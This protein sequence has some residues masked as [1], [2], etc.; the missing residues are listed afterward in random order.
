MEEAISRIL[1]ELEEFRHF[2]HSTTLHSHPPLSQSALFDLQTLLDNSISTD[3]Q[4]PLDRL[5]EDLS[6]KSL[7]PSSLTRAIA[8]AMDESSTCVSVLASTVYLSLLLASNAPVFTL[9]N[10]MDFLSFLRCVRRFLKQRPQGQQDQDDSNKESSAPKRKRKAGFKGKGLRKRPRQSSSGRYDD[11]ELD[12]RVLYP[13]LERLEILMSVIHLDRFPDSLKSLIETV[14]DI[15]VLALEICTNLS[16]YSKFTDFC[17]RILS[18]M[19]RP[20]D[21]DLSN[22]AVEVIKSLSPLILNHKDQARAFALE[23]VTIQIGKV[24]KE[25]DGVKSALVNLPRYLV[26][27]APEKSEPRSLAVDSIMEVVKALELP[28][29]IGFVDYAVK[30]TQGKSNLRLLAVD[31]ISMLIMSLSDP[32][33]I[34][35]KIELKDSWVFGCLVAL[36]QRCSDASAPIRARALTNLA[37]LVVFLSENDKNKALMKEILGPGDGEI[38]GLLRKRCVDQKAA[39]RKAALFLVTKCTTVLGGAMDGDMLKTVGI[40]CS[41][42]LVSIRKAAMSALSEAFRRFPDGSVMVEWLHS[43]PRLIADNES[44]IQEE[45]EHSFQELVLDR[46]ARA[47]S[48]SLPKG[49]LDLLK[50]IS[51]AEVIPWVKK[52]CANLGKKKRLKRTIADSLQVIIKTSESLWRS[53]SLPPEKWTAPPGAWF[54]LSEVSTYLGKA[55]D[56]E[57]LHQH[58]KLLDDHGRTVQSSVTQVGLF[59]E[60]NNSESNSVAWA[61]DRVFLLQTISNVS[62]E[63]PPEP[64]AD[65]AHELLKRV[66]EFNMHPTEV[67]AHVKTLKTLCKRK[68]SQS[69]EADALILKW[70]NQ[71]LSKASDILEKYISNH[72][73]A[74]KDVNFTTPP[75]KSGSR[76]GKKASARSKSLSEQS[77]QLTPLAL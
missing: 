60:K 71:L 31:L 4:Q 5:Y 24:A 50:E 66:E 20:E 48:S 1:T 52:V 53:Q 30:M 73:E 32:M 51:H 26:Q 12:A 9:F 17:S 47:E 44:S 74:N 10:P 67:N 56:W 63:L 61:Q 7:S 58:W 62:V 75:P 11:G 57:F 39:V 2:D 25:S 77:L 27:K 14:I 40:A 29:Q 69:T 8:S 70:V 72:A 22:T 76:M 18:A 55:I 59:G 28:D 68:A 33:V 42:P 19:L 16:I 23:F 6:A 65:L 13:V 64:A 38:L 37:H 34:D 54:L 21:G 45:C 15:P 36:V 41:D 35:S 3:E 43:I 49:V 46:L